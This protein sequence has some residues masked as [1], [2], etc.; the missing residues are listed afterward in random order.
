MSSACKS[1]SLDAV[2]VQRSLQTHSF[3]YVV[4]AW[5][6]GVVPQPVAFHGKTFGWRARTYADHTHTRSDSSSGPPALHTFTFHA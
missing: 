2:S 1:S 3:L 4:V 6:M 5:I